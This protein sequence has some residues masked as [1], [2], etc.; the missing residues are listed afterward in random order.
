[1]HPIERYLKKRSMTQAQIAKKVGI[2][3]GT[4]ANY[5]KG[6]RCPTLIIAYNIQEVTG[7]EVTM[8][9]LSLWHR[10]NGNG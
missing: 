3:A 7:D 6:R 9:E 1:M 2:T 4:V 10:E 8:K 5:I